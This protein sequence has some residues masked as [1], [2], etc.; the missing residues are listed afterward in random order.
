MAYQHDPDGPIVDKGA[1]RARII[2]VCGIVFIAGIIIFVVMKVVRPKSKKIDLALDISKI[3]L[4][5][6]PYNYLIDSSE[7][8]VTIS[9]WESGLTAISKKAFEGDSD[10]IAEWDKTKYNVLQYANAIDVNMVLED[11]DGVTIIIQVV[12]EN[13]HARKLLAFKDCSLVYDVTKENVNN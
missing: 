13:N 1:L 2:E 6:S 7:D 3:E 10:A 5:Y 8:V 9:L 4:K 12:N 11:V